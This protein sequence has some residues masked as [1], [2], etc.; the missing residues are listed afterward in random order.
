M[1]FK[2]SVRRRKEGQSYNN[3]HSFSASE[4]LLVLK[5]SGVV[6]RCCLSTV[7]CLLGQVVYTPGL[8]FS[9]LKKVTLFLMKKCSEFLTQ[10]LLYLHSYIIL[11]LTDYQLS[12]N[13]KFLPLYHFLV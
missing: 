1:A 9:H 3:S 11:S 8:L 7:A 13:K 6:L 2:V 10:R 12:T 5:R 4:Y